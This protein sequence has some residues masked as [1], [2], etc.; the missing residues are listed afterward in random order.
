MATVSAEATL[1]GRFPAGTSVTLVER[2]GDF[3]PEGPVKGKRFKVDE[4]SEVTVRGL[5][6]GKRY[7]VVGEVDGVQR[8][9][10][11]QGKLP[12]AQ[13]A[14]VQQVPPAQQAL[15]A[16]VAPRPKPGQA[17]SQTLAPGTALQVVTGARS[18]VSARGHHLR[19][20]ESPPVAANAGQPTKGGPPDEGHPHVRNEDVPKDQPQMSSTFTGQATPVDPS[21]PVPKPRQDQIKKGTPQ[22]SSTELGEATPVEPDEVQPNARQEDAKGKQ[23]SDTETGAAV[24]VP[25]EKAV[26]AQRQKDSSV[27]KARSATVPAA[28]TSKAPT[29]GQKDRQ[30]KAAGRLPK[31]TPKQQ[32]EKVREPLRQ[33]AKQEAKRGARSEGVPDKPSGKPADK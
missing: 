6:V 3:P 14:W 28:G 1:R 10:G 16:A 29:G 9:A 26:E 33:R 7:W 11:I 22:R 24:P 4:N 23:R 19:P 17:D 21:E 32:A 30:E 13:Q 2:T 31:K 18:T 27:S 20:G 8:S 25:R 12:P 15:L 5:E